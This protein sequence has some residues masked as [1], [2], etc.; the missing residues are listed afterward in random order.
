MRVPWLRRRLSRCPACPDPWAHPCWTRRADGSA[1]ATGPVWSSSS[2]CRPRW[3]GSGPPASS[4]A[5]SRSWR[6][7]TP[8]PVAARRCDRA[9]R[10]PAVGQ[11]PTRG[12]DTLAA[13]PNRPADVSV[14]LVARAQGVSLASGRVIDGYTLNGTTPGPTIRAQ[15]GQLVEVRVVNESVS[16]GMTLHWHGVDVPNAADGVAGVTQD[17]VAVGEEHPTVSSR[18]MRVPTGTTRTSCPTSRCRAACWG[19]SWSSHGRPRPCRR[20]PT[21]WPWSTSMQAGAQSTASTTS[22]GSRSH[23]APVR[24]SGSSTPTTAR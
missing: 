5:R 13:D 15:Q 17:A 19:L 3:P 16:D 14:T 10:G 9:R 18:G 7:G 11:A 4:P 21:S 20:T 12:V 2:P 1:G 6:W 22:P 24:E 23:L 8:M